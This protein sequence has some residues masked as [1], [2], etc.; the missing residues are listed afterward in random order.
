MFVLLKI[1]WIITR[2]FEKCLSIIKGCDIV[3]TFN[4]LILFGAKFPDYS[5]LGNDIIVKFIT[6]LL[7]I[8]NWT[9]DVQKG[10]IRIQRF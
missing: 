1:N 9:N 8:F 2:F 5:V 3:T 6:I 10:K 7:Q 4:H